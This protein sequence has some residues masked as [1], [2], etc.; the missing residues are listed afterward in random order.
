MEKNPQTKTESTW[1]VVARDTELRKKRNPQENEFIADIG[2]MSFIIK[3][4][5]LR[6]LR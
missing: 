5:V 6:P 1:S 2:G 4:R 3:N